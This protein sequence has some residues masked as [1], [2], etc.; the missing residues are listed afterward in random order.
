MLHRVGQIDEPLTIAMLSL[1]PRLRKS[2]GTR[3]SY[4]LTFDVGGEKSR[5]WS[6]IDQRQE[7]SEDFASLDKA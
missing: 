6:A 3:L 2:L 7:A 4:A 1:V 5:V